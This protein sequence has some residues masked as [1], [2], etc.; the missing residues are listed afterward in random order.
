M[1]FILPETEN[2]TLEDIELHFSDDSK[3]LTDLK[4]IKSNK[5][6]PSNDAEGVVEGTEKTNED[7]LEDDFNSKDIN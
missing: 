2:Y 7:K 6:M 5:M 3:K 4:I 1:Y